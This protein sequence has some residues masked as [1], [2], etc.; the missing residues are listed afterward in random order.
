MILGESLLMHKIFNSPSGTAAA[1]QGGAGCGQKS[2][3]Q[4]GDRCCGGVGQR[5]SFG[6]EGWQ[7]QDSWADEVKAGG[8]KQNG[9]AKNMGGKEEK[10]KENKE[11]AVGEK[12]GWEEEG[13]G[14]EPTWDEHLCLGQGG[15]FQAE[16]NFFALALNNANT[17]E[18]IKRWWDQKGANGGQLEGLKRQ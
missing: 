18:G 8:S 13:I 1:H 16:Q 6:V 10:V 14:E 9:K 4:L 7:Q 15:D 3:V 2:D 12:G 11:K 17:L 5:G